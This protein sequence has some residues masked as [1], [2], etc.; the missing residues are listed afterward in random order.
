MIVP[1]EKPYCDV[2][3]GHI[4][5]TSL[6]SHG[7]YFYLKTIEK[8]VIVIIGTFGD[9]TRCIWAYDEKEFKR[10]VYDFGK[11]SKADKQFFAQHVPQ[12]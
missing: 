10:V 9:M 3:I 6:H 2:Q 8:N 1:Q 11:L 7:N 4:F 12:L 5:T